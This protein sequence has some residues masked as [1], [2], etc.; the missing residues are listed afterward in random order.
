MKNEYMKGSPF[1]KPTQPQRNQLSKT[2]SEHAQEMRN[3]VR[4]RMRY[5]G[6]LALLGE[7]SAYMGNSS[8]SQNLREQIA[9][10]MLDAQ[11]V[12]PELKVKR[13]ANRF[14]LDL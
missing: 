1:S 13:V 14:N 6:V 7:A 10:A 8:A 9:A 12:I 4:I 11:K 3:Y 5:L 2:T